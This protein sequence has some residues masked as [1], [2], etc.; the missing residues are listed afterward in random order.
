M[1]SDRL[2]KAAGREVAAD[3]ELAIKAGRV[4]SWVV[5]TRPDGSKVVEVLD[6]LGKPK[7]IDTSKIIAGINLSGVKP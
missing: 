5:S 7:S 2:S 1:G 6:S 3:V 4:E